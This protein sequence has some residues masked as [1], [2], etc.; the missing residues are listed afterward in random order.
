MLG[1]E[2]LL[3]MS[4]PLMATLSGTLASNSLD[5]P[6]QTLQTGLRFSRLASN[7]SAGTSQVLFTVECRCL[8]L[9]SLFIC[10][11]YYCIRVYDV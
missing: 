10:V 5:W 7:S 4:F 8:L 3:L 6:P 11:N 2:V 9:D 1:L